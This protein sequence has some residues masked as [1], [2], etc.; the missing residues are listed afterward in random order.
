M[1]TFHWKNSLKTAA[2]AVVLSVAILGPWSSY[3]NAQVSGLLGLDNTINSLVGS[4]SGGSTDASPAPAPMNDNSDR[5]NS[6]SSSTS[7]ISSTNV[8]AIENKQENT[9]G[10][11]TNIV[12]TSEPAGHHEVVFAPHMTTTSKVVEKS[13]PLTPSSSSIA[14][15][16]TGDA[17]KI[18]EGPQ[19]QQQ[20]ANT[21]AIGKPTTTLVTSMSSPTPTFVDG[22]VVW[23]TPIHTVVYKRAHASNDTLEHSDSTSDK[24]SYSAFGNL[25]SILFVIMTILLSSNT[26]FG[27]LF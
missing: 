14:N 15:A 22:K 21:A 3:E 19:P 17:S 16:A 11:Q 1:S 12:H 5:K 7:P 25:L 26:G 24:L 18:V 10:S 20:H 27:A 13:V 8:P 23:V 4:K 9:H 2:V 6:Q